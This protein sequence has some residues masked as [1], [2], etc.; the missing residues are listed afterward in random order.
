MDVHVP[1]NTRQ[2]HQGR[3][4][5]GALASRIR[6]GHAHGSHFS[7]VPRRAAPKA[8]GAVR[9]VPR[10]IGPPGLFWASL[11]GWLLLYWFR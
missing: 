11:S 2:L 4:L 10:I 1:C 6:G 3:Q 7:P 8:A 5:A 9:G